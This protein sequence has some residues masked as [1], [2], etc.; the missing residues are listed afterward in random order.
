M[1]FW[2]AAGGGCGD[3]ARLD[4]VLPQLHL[5]LGLAQLHQLR[6]RVGRGARVSFCILLAGDSISQQS[7]ERLNL[8]K[9]TNDGFELAEADL[10]LRGPGDVTGTRQTG[11]LSFKVADLSQH[12]HLLDQIASLSETIRAN[13]G[14]ARDQLIERWIGHEEHFV[15]V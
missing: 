8:L 3:A 4:R 12:A 1:E 9:N 13:H 7:R 15:N 2:G 10:R 6:G 14:E 5:A 11:E